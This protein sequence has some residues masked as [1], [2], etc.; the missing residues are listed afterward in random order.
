MTWLLMWLN[1]SVATLNATLQLLVIYKLRLLANEQ[2]SYT[3][4]K[5]AQYTEKFDIIYIYIYFGGEVKNEN[6]TGDFFFL[7]KKMG[8]WGPHHGAT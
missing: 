2:L 4:R 5:P 1:V 3:S 8:R 7:M 6:R